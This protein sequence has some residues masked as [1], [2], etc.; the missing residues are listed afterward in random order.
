MPN[1]INRRNRRSTSGAISPSQVGLAAGVAC[2]SIA[3][4]LIRA[5]GNVAKAASAAPNEAQAA[6]DFQSNSGWPIAWQRCCQA[7][8]ATAAVNPPT[9][10]PVVS[11]ASRRPTNRPRIAAG[12]RSPNHDHRATTPVNSSA[13]QSAQTT[14][15][16]TTDRCESPRAPGAATIG[17]APNA[18]ALARNIPTQNRRRLPSR[19]SQ[20]G[21]SNRDSPTI[22]GAARIH[23]IAAPLAWSSRAKYAT[24]ETLANPLPAPQTTPL[25]YANDNERRSGDWRERTMPPR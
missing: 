21:V 25:A 7:H 3:T 13:W 4:S 8:V 5:S 19:W 12:T 11:Q 1:N 18:A 17:S 10:S 15:S 22:D 23:A 14:P 20:N 24:S 9:T 2:R 6:Y 16:A